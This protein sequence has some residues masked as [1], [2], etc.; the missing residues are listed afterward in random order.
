MYLGN[1]HYGWWK[2][3]TSVN[4]ENTD[5]EI[6]YRPADQE[7]IEEGQKIKEE[8]IKKEEQSEN[9]NPDSEKKIVSVTIVDAAQYQDGIEVRAFAD[10]ITEDGE[11]TYGFSK[12]N[13][14]F[15]RKMPAKADAASTPCAALNLKPEDFTQAGTWE[16]TVRYVSQNATGF[17]KT[18][19]EVKK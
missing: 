14:S 4:L 19:L 18:T 6:N 2:Q 7:V 8:I 3:K 15:T 12:N 11:C 9:Q 13:D 17:A 1:H 16:V 10:K 5:S